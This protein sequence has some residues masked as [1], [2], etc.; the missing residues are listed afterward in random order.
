[1]GVA[2]GMCGGG[3]RHIQ[4]FGGE[5]WGKETTWKAQ[6][7]WEDN[8]KMDLQEVGCGAWTGSIWVRIGTGGGHLWMRQWTFGF[9]K[10]RGI[11]WLAENL[12]ASRRALLYG[13]SKYVW[14][15]Q[16]LILFF[17]FFMGMCKVLFEVYRQ[18][19]H[20]CSKRFASPGLGTMVTEFYRRP[21]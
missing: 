18:F 13:V 21:D 20:A 4:G 5:T 19:G 6:A 16:D 1:M 10:M 15:I 8:I 2:C 14:K 11:S 3:K 12:L 17:K 7:R 9:H